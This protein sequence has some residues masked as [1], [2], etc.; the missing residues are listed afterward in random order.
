MNAD[1]NDT[2]KAGMSTQKK[3]LIG[4]GG[5]LGALIILAIILA[6]IGWF[7]GN[8]VKDVSN[9]S[10]Q[11]IFGPTYKPEGYMAVGLPLGQAN[12]KNMVM[13]LDTQRGKMLIAIDMKLRANDMHMI[14]AGQPEQVKKYLEQTSEEISKGNSGSSKVQDIRFDS[15]ESVALMPGGVKFPLANATVTAERRNQT[16]YSPAV[17]ALI[18]EADDKMVVL[19]ATD[20]NHSSTDSQADFTEEQKTLREEVLQIIRDSDLDDRLK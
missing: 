1:V 3:W 15:I 6:V 9:K 19:V 16:A 5:C 14:K 18:P 2:P 8:T 10:V 4:C 7:V 17:A 13:L 20:P 11:E 12:V